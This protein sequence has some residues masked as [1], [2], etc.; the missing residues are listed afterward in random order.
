MLRSKTARL[1]PTALV[2]FV[3]LS[4]WAACS[5]NNN[6]FFNS[7]PISGGAQ[8]GAAGTAGQASG[9]SGSSASGGTHATAGSDGSSAK[10][11]DTSVGGTGANGGSDGSSA[12][13]GDTSVG[14]TSANGGTSASGGTGANGGMSASGG[15][16][17]NDTGGAGDAN[18]LAEGGV[19]SAGAS[20]EP[21]MSGGTSGTGATSGVGGS[22]GDS[23]SS[24]GTSGV[25]G[26]SGSAGASGTGAAGL[27][28]T[29][30]AGGSAGSANAGTAGTSSTQ[31][32]SDDNGCHS[33]QFC[34]KSSCNAA[35]GQCKTKP[36]SCTGS[37]ATF[38]P[39]CG[40][41]HMTYYSP[42]VADREG[43][44]VATDGECPANGAATC[45]RTGGS[46]QSCSPT[47]T[48]AACLRSR[49]SC[50]GTAPNDGVCW[51]LP[52]QCPTESKVNRYCALVSGTAG[53]Y[54]LCEGLAAD[55]P[56]WRDSNM[57][58]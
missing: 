40:C 37:D 44:N 2:S 39:V 42:C 13:G 56:L 21:G 38:T 10:G 45:T 41:D 47:R 53:C 49:T 23:N 52:D 31:T 54:G 14:G 18:G 1:R 3:G 22:S 7:P 20:G 19:P 8:S 4:L 29:S 11:G 48:N 33:G 25:G 32:C 58:P 26:S 15:T 9:A 17:A 51:V 43:V 57:C 35:T 16:G 34:A 36:T 55:Y 12:K 28:G 27:G 5:G 6:D 30:G 24:G 50:S 46:G